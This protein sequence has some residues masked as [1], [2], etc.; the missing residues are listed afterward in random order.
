VSR[1]TPR[2]VERPKLCRINPNCVASH[3]AAPRR[4]TRFLCSCK[5]V[6]LLDCCFLPSQGFHRNQ[7]FGSSDC[8]KL[9]K[10]NFSR[11]LHLT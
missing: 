8:T 1:A 3:R 5:Q 9:L 7:P 2:D 4:A 11:S 10:I 6:S